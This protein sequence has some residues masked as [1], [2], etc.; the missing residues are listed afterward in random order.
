LD[1]RHFAEL[2]GKNTGKLA[3]ALLI[4]KSG[5]FGEANEET[6]RRMI[7]HR[8]GTSAALPESLVRRLKKIG[9]KIDWDSLIPLSPAA[10]KIVAAM[11]SRRPK[12][13]SSESDEE[14]L[15]G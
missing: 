2:S 12:E 15:D 1:R 3:S 5:I 6:Y 8:R 14:E 4:I 13:D 7:K 9:K 10:A 11:K